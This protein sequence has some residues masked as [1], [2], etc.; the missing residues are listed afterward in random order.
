MRGACV[1][2]GSLLQHHHGVLVH[3]ESSDMSKHQ[4]KRPG[5]LGE[6]ERLDEQAR[7]SDLPPAAAAHPAPELLLPGPSSPRRL[8]LERAE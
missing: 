3:G 5:H 8:L 7:V 1:P 6:I 4:V 2:N